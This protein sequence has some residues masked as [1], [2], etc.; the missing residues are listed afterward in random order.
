MSAPERKVEYRGTGF[1]VGLVAILLFALVLLVLAVQNTQEVDVAFFGWLFT[2]PLFAVA[3][4]AAL[5]AVVLDELIGL[6]WRRRR[7]A[8]LEERTELDRLRT[9]KAHLSEEGAPV[10]E[11]AGEAGM[12]EQSA[13]TPTS[14]LDDEGTER[15]QH[16]GD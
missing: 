10:E 14:T 9:V 15:T 5:L 11:E 3:I 6:V 12:D 8:L 7:R 13:E 4:G 16:E 1:Y 2:V